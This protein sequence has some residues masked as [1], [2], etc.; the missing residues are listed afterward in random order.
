M[1]L[2]HYVIHY[3]VGG[4]I[5]TEHLGATDHDDALKWGRQLAIDRGWPPSLFEDIEAHELHPNKEQLS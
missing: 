2:K 4:L 1:T 5:L 3:K